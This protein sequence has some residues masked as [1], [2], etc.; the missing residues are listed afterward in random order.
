MKG[1]SRRMF[2]KR[3][4]IAVAMAGMATSPLLTGATSEATTEAAALPEGAQLTEP[5]VAHLRDLTTGEI[6]V[7]VGSRQVVVND[8]KLAH[9]LFRASR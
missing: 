8:P 7:F 9:A 2:L 5:V 3:G 6:N 1:L 4:S